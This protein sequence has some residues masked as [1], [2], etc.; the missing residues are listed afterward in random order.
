MTGEFATLYDLAKQG[1]AEAVIVLTGNPTKG[2][3]LEIEIVTTEKGEV[4][5]RERIGDKESVDWAAQ[6]LHKR[7]KKQGMM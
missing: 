4:L 7:L 1:G 2:H 3:K 5:D 6:R